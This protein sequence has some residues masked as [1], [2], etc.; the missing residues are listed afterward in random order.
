[1]PADRSRT[2]PDLF[3][4]RERRSSLPS[5]SVI[6]PTLNE[7]ENLTFVLNSLPEW[8]DEVVVVDGRSS[9][10]TE[11][12]ARSLWPDVRIVEEARPGKGA[13]MQTGF[14]AARGDI[15]ISLDADGSMDG[16][17]VAAFRDALVA[18]ADYVKGCRFCRGGGSNDITRIRRL[19][20]RTICLLIRTLFGVRYRDATYGYI[21]LWADC[22]EMVDIDTDGF[23][24]ETLIGIRAHRAGLRMAEVPCFEA[25]RIHG[26]SNLSALGDGLRIL[27]V[28]SREV[29]RR[30]TKV[31]D[32][33][34]SGV[35][36]PRTASGVVVAGPGSSSTVPGIIVSEIVR[37]LATN[38]RVLRVEVDPH[39]DFDAGLFR[40]TS[41][42]ATSG[43]SGGNVA[44]RRLP[45]DGG[46]RE[47]SLRTWLGAE[48]ST[49]IAVAWPG[50]DTSWIGD[51]V[52]LARSAGA[53]S[54][55]LCASVPHPDHFRV[56]TFAHDVS[57]AD[58]VLIGDVAEASAL[59]AMLGPAGPVVE[60]HHT[61]SLKGRGDQPLD[62]VVTAF[63]PRDDG[64]TLDTLLSAFDAIPE[65]RIDQYRLRV[66]MR[67]K[68]QSM[69]ERVARSFHAGHVELIDTDLTEHELDRLCRASSVFVVA[70]PA[71][72]SRAYGK[73]VESGIS[74]VV[75]SALPLP[76]ALGDYAGGLLADAHRS[77]SIDVALE[78]ALRLRELRFSSPEAWG[79]LVERLV[80]VRLRGGRAS[81]AFGDE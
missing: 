80:G 2:S 43:A 23:G 44:T 77:A 75:L 15:V 9:D 37:A 28:I 59:V 78:H 49:A 58:L 48:T 70:D 41:L 55:V 12:V 64:P 16:S 30:P 46:Q 34:A 6:I 24:V 13:A 65:S 66:V 8:I 3:T 14:R 25:K 68:D 61:L 4:K 17:A 54:V 47:D 69:A 40:A 76:E 20:D 72:D 33:S 39:E 27:G 71:F 63:L 35:H 11:R 5:V 50:L 52:R 32:R 79:E 26:S 1:M 10:D 29:L 56:S 21:G 60:V 51:F 36:E 7:S 73:A 74:T 81:H 19:G 38:C 42:V 31:N 18:G 22:V 53:T 62:Y 45:R 67:S 57:G